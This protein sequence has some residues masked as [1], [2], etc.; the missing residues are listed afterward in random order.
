MTGPGDFSTY[1]L[2]LVDPVTGAT[3]L[4]FDPQLSETFSFKAGCP[5]R[6]DCRPQ[7]TCPPSAASSSVT[8]YL[9]KDFDSFR[10]LMLD[11][12]ATTIRTGATGTPRTSR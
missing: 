6:F 4:G 8:D 3:P 12:L 1:R 5:I 2:R 9:A 10:Q 7:V 11:R